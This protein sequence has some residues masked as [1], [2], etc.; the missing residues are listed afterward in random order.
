MTEV[1]SC[2]ENVTVLRHWDAVETGTAHFHSFVGVA[3]RHDQ[4]IRGY[5]AAAG[6]LGKRRVKRRNSRVSIPRQSR[7]ILTP[8]RRRIQ[9]GSA[10]LTAGNA[11]SAAF[12][13]L[14]L[15]R[16]DVGNDIQYLFLIHVSDNWYH[17]LR[18]ASVSRALL[19]VVELP[20]H[21]AR[22]ASGDSGHRP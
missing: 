11:H 1:M 20:R 9:I 22:R 13:L 18:P 14:R 7:G 19:H 12:V 15:Q 3:K 2:L 6:A 16:R 5:E 4:L 17:Q 8:T 10:E 21:I